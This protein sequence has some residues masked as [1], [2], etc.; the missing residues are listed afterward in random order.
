M[1]SVFRPRAARLLSPL[2]N[3]GALRRD[4]VNRESSKRPQQENG[5]RRHRGFLSL[6]IPSFRERRHRTKT[7]DVSSSS[8]QIL[9]HAHIL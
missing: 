6:G 4:L 3:V 8:P 5:S 7:C 1:S 9:G 2:M